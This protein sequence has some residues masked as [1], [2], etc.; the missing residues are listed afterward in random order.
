MRKSKSLHFPQKEGLRIHSPS[1]NHHTLD[2][3]VRKQL[4][5]PPPARISPQETPVC[6][7]TLWKTRNKQIEHGNEKGEGRGGG[8]GSGR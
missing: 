2:Q 1:C 3:F 4:L 7:R 8:L 5:L 6:W